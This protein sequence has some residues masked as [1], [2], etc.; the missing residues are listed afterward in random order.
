METVYATTESCILGINKG[1]LAVLQKALIEKRNQ[2]DFYIVESVLKGNYLLKQQWR[3]DI[4]QGKTN[5]L[6]GNSTLAHDSKPESVE[7]VDQ[8]R[9]TL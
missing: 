5:L 1:K 6:A 7:M 2:K 4:A 3:Q 9:N 8:F